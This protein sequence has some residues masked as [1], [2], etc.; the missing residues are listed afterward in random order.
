M[1]IHICISRRGFSD[2]QL[3]PT[4]AHEIGHSIGIRHSD[5]EESMMWPYENGVVKLHEDD[6]N[7]VQAHYGELSCEAL[8]TCYRGQGK[9]E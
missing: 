4:M 6:V 3:L 9:W 8:S 5:V 1:V 7:A 2:F